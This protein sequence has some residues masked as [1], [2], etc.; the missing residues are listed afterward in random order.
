MAR[1]FKIIMTVVDRECEDAT[2]KQIKNDYQ[3]EVFNNGFDIDF[4]IDNIIEL[5]TEDLATQ[6]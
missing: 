2:L 5:S 4:T 3:N 1:K 6:S